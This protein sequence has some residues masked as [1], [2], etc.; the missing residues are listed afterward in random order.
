M[1][2][3]QAIQ[4]V[5]DELQDI[6][7]NN[8][9]TPVA[10]KVEDSI[11]KLQTALDELNKTPPDN[12]AAMGIVK[13]AVVDLVAALGL[14]P[15]QEPVLADLMDQLAGIARQ[16]AA[17]PVNQA[18]GCDPDHPD[19]IDAQQALEDG[20]A[21]RATGAFEDAVTKYNDGLAKAEGVLSS[22]PSC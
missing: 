16:L 17:G 22:S 9:G 10:D 20:D 12:Q 19:I 21:L 15:A 14:D 7:D 8:P 11:A 13:G 3:Q 1:D 4:D 2:A 18:L 6:T 5:I